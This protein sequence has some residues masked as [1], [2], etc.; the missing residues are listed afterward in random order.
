MNISETVDTIIELRGAGAG[1]NERVAEYIRATLEASGALV[2]VQ[3]TRFS[4]FSEA[5]VVATALALSVVFLTSVV[6]RRHRAA[7][8]SGLVIPLILFFEFTLGWHV[9]CW[10]MHK[11]SENVVAHFPVQDAARRVVMGTRYTVP[12]MTA[13]GRFAQTV[14]AFLPPIT[15]VAALLALWQLGLH[16]GKFDFEDAHTIMMIMAAVC[17]VYY[18][19]AFGVHSARAIPVRG[20][21]ALMRNAGSIATLAALSE[22][23]SQKYPRLDSTWVSVAFFGG[24]SEGHGA[25]SFAKRLARDRNSVLPTFF[26][27]CEQT[28]GGGSHGYLIPGNEATSSL[29]ADRELIRTLNRAA[30]AT[31]GSPLEIVSGDA[32]DSRAFAKRGFPAAVLTTL[33]RDGRDADKGAES[34]EIDRGQLLLSLQL[35]EA[36]LAEFDKPQFP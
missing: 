28:G 13:S 8:V 14:S 22:D 29:D 9:I 32:A 23:L 34:P 12:T 6:K 36:A 35:L 5:F 4:S 1:Q 10:P 30:V 25:G 17:S 20:D 31:T 16:F 33:S 21:R 24:G 27:G 15:I 2:E 7:A 18:A 11:K 26:V 19:V 3:T